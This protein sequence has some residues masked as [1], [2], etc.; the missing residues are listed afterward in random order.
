M[1]ANRRAARAI[2]SGLLGALIVTSCGGGGS[3]ATSA[4]AVVKRRHQLHR[5]RCMERQ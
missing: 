5:Q 3:G 2:V 1:H 4:P